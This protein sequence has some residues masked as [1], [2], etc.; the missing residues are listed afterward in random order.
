MNQL[1]GMAVMF[2]G[3]ALVSWPQKSVQRLDED[4]QKDPSTAAA[5]KWGIPISGRKIGMS[6]FVCGR[7]TS[8][9]PREPMNHEP[10]Q[11]TM[12][13]MSAASTAVQKP[14]NRETRQHQRHQ[15]EHGGVDHQQEQPERQHQ[16]RQRQ[17]Q[18]EGPHDGV[19]HA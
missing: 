11:L 6:P 1:V 8:T 12:L 14:P 10:T 16:R 3:V 18:R 2:A 5:D 19:D 17:Q 15:A 9:R 13:T 4:Q 7:M